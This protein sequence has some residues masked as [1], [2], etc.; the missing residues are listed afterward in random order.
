[1]MMKSLVRNSPAVGQV[2]SFAV[3]AKDVYNSTSFSGA[4]KLS[5]E[6]AHFQ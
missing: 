3:T 1:M 5:G 4:C 2:A 6:L